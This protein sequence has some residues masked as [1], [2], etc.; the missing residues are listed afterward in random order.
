[1]VG[2]VGLRWSIGGGGVV[3]LVAVSKSGMAAVKAVVGWGGVGGV[4]EGCGWWEV[5]NGA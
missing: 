2:A 4:S 5:M 1:M 3:E